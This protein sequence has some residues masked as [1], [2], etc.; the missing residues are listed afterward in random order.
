[1]GAHMSGVI[2]LIF[3]SFPAFKKLK[4]VSPNPPET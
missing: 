1:M 2:I 4:G 3:I